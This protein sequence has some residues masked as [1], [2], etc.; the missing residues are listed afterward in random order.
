MIIVRL[1]RPDVLRLLWLTPR[2]YPRPACAY[3]Q[4]TRDCT[5]H[6]TLLQPD[7]GR[8]HPAQTA[9]RGPSGRAGSLPQY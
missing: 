6:R 4:D 3:E 1:L 8:R 7:A 5:G 2:K 9:Y